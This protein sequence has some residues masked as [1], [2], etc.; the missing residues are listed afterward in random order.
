S[1]IYIVN[2]GASIWC[3]AALA[4]VTGAKTPTQLERALQLFALLGICLMLIPAFKYVSAYEREPWLWAFALALV[5]PITLLYQRKL[6]PEPFLPV[7]SVLLLMAW[8]KRDRWQG[9]LAWG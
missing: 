4:K 3:F 6:W 7:F 1:G 2:P 5:N 9:A 8:W